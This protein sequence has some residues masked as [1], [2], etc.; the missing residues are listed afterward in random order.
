[1]EIE[2]PWCDTSCSASKGHP[3]DH[4]VDCEVCGAFRLDGYSSVGEA[5]NR[6]TAVQRASLSHLVRTQWDIRQS[7]QLGIPPE[8]RPVPKPAKVNPALVA[9]A[10]RGEF[11]VT[12]AQQADNA[13]KY[14]GDQVHSEGHPTS[15]SLDPPWFAAVIGAPNGRSAQD[16]IRELAAA[17]LVSWS[18][19]AT[20]GPAKPRAD[21]TLT[22]WERYEAMTHGSREGGYGFFAWE[23]GSTKTKRVFREVLQPK[24]DELG[25]PLRDMADLAEPGLIDNIM[26]ARIRNATFVIVDLTDGNH[27]AYWEGGFAQA[28]DKPVVYI[29][30][31]AAFKETKP[32]FD[33]NHYTIVFWGSLDKTDDQFVEELIATLRR[34]PKRL[35][36]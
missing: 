4:L 29:M 30:H 22:G 33:T 31:E 15:I 34:H 18:V 10:Q 21:L 25:V 1:M 36:L 23:F 11:L 5:A 16:L 13:I 27:G 14:I 28:L 26:Q 35:D 24:F 20:L 7:S 6:L 32:H 19:P 17:G 12:R 8:E 2:C 3:F 9:R